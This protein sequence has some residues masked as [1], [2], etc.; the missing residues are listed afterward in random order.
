MYG[1]ILQEISVKQVKIHLGTL[2]AGFYKA[3][4]VAFNFPL[5]K[6]FSNAILTHARMRKLQLTERF[7]VLL[8]SRKAQAS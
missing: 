6:M 4:I 5:R 1:M 3:R 7:L 8:S 2:K